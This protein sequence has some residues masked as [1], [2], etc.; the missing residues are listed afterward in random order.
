M[1]GCGRDPDWLAGWVEG[2]GA[3]AAAA[4]LCGG[5]NGWMV[6]SLYS[7]VCLF[8]CFSDSWIGGHIK[9][10]SKY[11]SSEWLL[12]GTLCMRDQCER[13]AISGRALCADIVL[14]LYSFYLFFLHEAHV[15]CPKQRKK[16][17]L[18]LLC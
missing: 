6:V 15:K 8:L 7:C 14:I 12:L 10:F 3:A 18:L 16:C 13:K 1:T 17:C 4:R 9:R 5:L 2:A 11:L